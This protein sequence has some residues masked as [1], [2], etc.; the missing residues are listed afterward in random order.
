MKSVRVKGIGVQVK[1]KNYFKNKMFL[2]SNEDYEEI[3]EYVEVIEEVKENKSI[4]DDDTNVGTNEPEKEITEEHTKEESEDNNGE[5]T[6][7]N[8]GENEEDNESEYEEL[9][10]LRE[11]AKALGIK[12]NNKMKKETIIKKIEEKEPKSGE[13][14]NPEG[15]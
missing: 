15:E 13:D 10:A 1:G 9:E 6:E 7:E 3:K 5:N 11:R 14:Q 12:I 4:N 8:T 2:V